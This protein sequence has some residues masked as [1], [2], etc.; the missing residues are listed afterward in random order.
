MII[1]LGQFLW[2][3]PD[4]EY[5]DNNQVTSGKMLASHAS[6][7]LSVAG[8]VING[9]AKKATLRAMYANSNI[10]DDFVEAINALT[11]W[12]NS[13][14]NNPDTG[15]PNPTIMVG[16]WQSLTDI[17]HAM[18]IDSVQKLTI[19]GVDVATRPG[20]SWGNDFTPFINNGIIPYRVFNDVTASNWE[21][22]ITTPIQFEDSATFTALQATW[23][24]ALSLSMLLVIMVV[25]MQK[26][27]YFKRRNSHI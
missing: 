18:P 8:G 27:N 5:V 19:G 11:S 21:W 14:S 25:L 22:C 20:A 6:S 16:E 4:L 10:D 1:V 26:R 7:V 3:G 12:H 24:Q 17:W 23:M 13:K 15:V 9:F 2:I